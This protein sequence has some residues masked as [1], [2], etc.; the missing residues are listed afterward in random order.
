MHSHAIRFEIDRIRLPYEGVTSIYTE[1]ANEGN[2][3]GS[4]KTIIRG[5]PPDLPYAGGIARVARR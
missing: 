5:V 1:S 2:E 3:S 4:N